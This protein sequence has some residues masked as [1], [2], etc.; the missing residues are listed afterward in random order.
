MSSV[1]FVERAQRMARLAEN[2]E[3]KRVGDRDVARVN[4]ARRYGFTPNFLRALRYCPPKT[5]AV[6]L[7]LKL[8]LAVEDACL[9]QIQI[10]EATL[11]EV[12]EGRKSLRK[13]TV[14]EAETALSDV[15]AI[16]RESV[17]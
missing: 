5:I 4:L 17:E 12:R 11:E 6:D 3:Y 7:F 14:A 16:L 10:S 8:I 1:A 9:Y 2:T 15:I 13:I